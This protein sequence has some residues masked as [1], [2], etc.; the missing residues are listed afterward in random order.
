[1]E[2]NGAVYRYALSLKEGGSCAVRVAGP[3]GS[4]TAEGF[5][6]WDG[7][8]FKLDAAFDRPVL[9]ALRSLRRASAARFGG[10]SFTI[11]AP[12][13]SYRQEQVRVTFYRGAAAWS[14]RP[15]TC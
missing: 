15:L 10:N 2:S 13:D 1:M 5:W 7:S 4:Q 8:I 12:P 9:P 11:M 6:S 3:T 14:S